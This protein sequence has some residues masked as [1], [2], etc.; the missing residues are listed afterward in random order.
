MIEQ[1]VRQRLI[2][3]KTTDDGEEAYSIHRVLQQKIQFDMDDYSYADAFRKAF[4]LIRKKFPYA[5]P[6]QVPNAD[7]L[8]PCS[9]Y[10]PHVFSFDKVF[11]DHFNDHSSAGMRETRAEELAQLF[12]DAGFY[13]WAGQTT[14]YDGLS[15]LQAAD[16]ILNKMQ[17]DPEAKLRADIHC[18]TGLL[19]LNMGYAERARGTHRLKE[20]LKIRKIIYA[21][22]D[23]RN[24]DIL[25]QNAANDYALSLMNEYRFGKAGEILLECHERYQTWGPESENPF[26]NSKFYGN[27]SAV[28]L[29]EE[30]IDE[31][32]ASVKRCLDLTEKLAGG[33]DSQYYRRMFWLGNMQLQAGDHQ[34]A[35]DTQLEV[36][37][38]RLRLQG[39]HNEN[40]ILSMYAVGAAFHYRGDLPSAM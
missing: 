35:L 5:S 1:L 9:R 14:A 38:Q 30:K 32:I 26:E 33:K 28:L 6:T 19:L 12:Y 25:V 36:L 16:D 40:T 37:R 2:T 29:W 18:M 22:D 13:V 4:R 34:A 8:E 31:A 11:R 17:Y 24:N 21:K 3:T 39:K 27:Y 10:M 7:S 15:F 20:A 23:T